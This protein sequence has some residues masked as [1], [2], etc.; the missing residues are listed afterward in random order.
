MDEVDQQLLGDL[1]LAEQHLIDAQEILSK[2]LYYKCIL[3]SQPVKNHSQFKLH[4][5][6]ELRIYISN[7]T[8]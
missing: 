6:D 8:M 1:T 7:D 4:N 5:I 3:F 2:V